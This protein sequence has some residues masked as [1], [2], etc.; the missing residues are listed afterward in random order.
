MALRPSPVARERYKRVFDL[1]LVALLLPLVALLLAAAALAVLLEGRGPVLYTQSRYG[2]GGRVFRMYKLRTMAPD[3]ERS[4]GPVQAARGDARA[5]PVGRWLRLYHLDEL[6][7]L[8]NVVRG[9]MSLV[10]PRPE[11]PAL[12]TRIELSVPGFGKRLAIRPGIAG[13]A[14]WRGP[15]DLSPRHKVRYD[16]LY[17]ATM[18]PCLDLRLFALC[19]WRTLRP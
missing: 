3:A 4:T 8:L 15:S 16:E 7:Q 12:Q 17:I 9:E 13:L 14:Q 1:T 2:R 18:G 5:T 19:V 11:R 6:P 10:G